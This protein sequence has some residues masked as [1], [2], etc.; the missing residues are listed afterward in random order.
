MNVSIQ[1]L[2]D[3]NMKM[4]ENEKD[5]AD[6][7]AKSKGEHDKIL[8]ELHDAQHTI[9]NYKNDL[10]DDDHSDDA[11][12]RIEAEEFNR[13]CKENERLQQ[14]LDDARAKVTEISTVA[15]TQMLGEEKI[16][17][18]NDEIFKE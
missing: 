14:E 10:A 6:Q 13:V 15:S 12:N 18:S 9:D 7:L 4:K 16:V 11:S 17:S 3:D 5:L 2:E 1:E 8:F